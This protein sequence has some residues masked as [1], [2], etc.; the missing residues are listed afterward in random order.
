MNPHLHAA[1]LDGMW[2]EE[3]GGLVFRGLGHLRTSEV[4]EVLERT[5][6]RIEKS[7]GRRGRRRRRLK[8]AYADGTV[9]VDPPHRRRWGQV[10]PLSLLCR[11]A[12]SVPPPRHHTVRDAG[13]LGAASEW[14]S[15]IVPAPRGGDPGGGE[16]GT[17]PLVATALVDPVGAS[18]SR[19]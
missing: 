10:D 11:L 4:G 3:E 14:R 8:R 7:L 17:A 16:G 9:A 5:I 19:S 6:V 18:R 1:F 13:V 15:W 2:H 12:A